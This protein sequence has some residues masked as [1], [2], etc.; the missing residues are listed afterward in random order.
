MII[1]QK[2]LKTQSKVIIFYFIREIVVDGGVVVKE[3][4]ISIPF[5][6]KEKYEIFSVRF[7]KSDRF[8]GCSTSNGKIHLLDPFTFKHE[9]RIHAS[10]FAV[11]CIRFKDDGSLMSVSADGKVGTWHTKTGK[12]LH[13]LEE[14]NN[15]IMCLDINAE[16]NKFATGGNDKLV[17]LYDDETKTLISELKPTYSEVGHS[18]RIFSVNFHRSETHLLASGGWDSI[19]VFYD[20]REKRVIGNV[21][22]AHICGDSLDM[23]DNYLLT[24]SWRTKEQIKIFDIRKFQLVETVDWGFD[25]EEKCCYAYSAQFSKKSNKRNLFAVG[26]SHYNMWRVWEFEETDRKKSSG[27]DKLPGPAYSL[28]FSNST[29]DTLA[30]GCGDGKVRIYD[31][32]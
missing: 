27:S 14:T 12:K 30:V 31:L 8:L 9:M 32:S 15:P 4:G 7:S 5:D 17:R 19:V 18:N 23:K 16:A 1:Y 24:G 6:K 25:E 20:I 2:S 22:G 11:T 10:D 13:T 3:R 29:S 28:D 26:G 21:L